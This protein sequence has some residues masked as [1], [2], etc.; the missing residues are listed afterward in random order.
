LRS[1]EANAEAI[2]KTGW[3]RNGW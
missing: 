2:S 1:E 3:K